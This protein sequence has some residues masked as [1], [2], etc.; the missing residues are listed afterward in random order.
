M[1]NVAGWRVLFPALFRVLIL[2]L[3]VIS[4][5][6]DW[7][8]AASAKAQCMAQRRSVDAWM[9]TLEGRQQFLYGVKPLTPREATLAYWVDFD[10]SRLELLQALKNEDLSSST[11]SP[12]AD[13]CREYFRVVPLMAKDLSKAWEDWGDGQ[14]SD[15]ILEARVDLQSRL[16]KLALESNPCANEKPLLQAELMKMKVGLD[17]LRSKGL[18]QRGLVNVYHLSSRVHAAWTEKADR[19]LREYIPRQA[20]YVLVSFLAWELVVGRHVY[21]AVEAHRLSSA[22]A[23]TA[24]MTAGATYAAAQG[25]R[26]SAELGRHLPSLDLNEREVRMVLS[27]GESLSRFSRRDPAPHAS[28]I[29]EY[30][31]ALHRELTLRLY[32]VDQKLKPYLS[33]GW[34]YEGLKSKWEKD[35]YN[36]W[37]RCP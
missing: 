14:E 7:A 36:L 3:G 12:G 24:K 25:G 34:T 30:E 10:E 37:R 8:E 20:A 32:G 13:L 19:D 17:K 35:R 29:L 11:P 28:W 26:V 23:F 15:A 31:T 21:A 22:T 1:L 2:G 4:G 9:Q 6:L 33:K 16:L 5:S 27:S 18:L